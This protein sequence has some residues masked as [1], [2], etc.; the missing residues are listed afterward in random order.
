MPADCRYLLVLRLKN[1][2]CSQI[3]II[4]QNR[5][6]SH[7]TLNKIFCTT[8]LQADNW[9]PTGNW[10]PDSSWQASLD[11]PL[12]LT[13]KREETD[14]GQSPTEERVHLSYMPAACCADKTDCKDQWLFRV[15]FPRSRSLTHETGHRSSEYFNAPHHQSARWLEFECRKQ[16]DDTDTLQLSN[17]YVWQS[18][19]SLSKFIEPIDPGGGESEGK[20]SW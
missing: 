12:R 20:T 13:R 3:W 15:F 18:F 7:S 11:P 16:T 14:S 6:R 2:S 10:E 8:D 4:S 17:E 1:G 9:H 19:T 5:D